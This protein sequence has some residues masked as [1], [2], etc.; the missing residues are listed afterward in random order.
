MNIAFIGQEDRGLS[1][2]R[3]GG[4]ENCFRRLGT[5][6]KQSG[7]EVHYIIYG[8]RNLSGYYIK[9]GDTTFC[10]NYRQLID[11]IASVRADIYNIGPM[12]IRGRLWPLLAKLRRRGA[13]LSTIYWMYP[14]FTGS[15]LVK[16]RSIIFNATIF[17]AIFGGSH[18]IEADLRKRRLRS[19]LLL[20]PIDKCFYQQN[21]KRLKDKKLRVFGY[22]GRI[23][24]DK[25][26]DWFLRQDM[27]LFKMHGRELRIYGYW[28]SGDS[29]SVHF[30]HLLA[31]RPEIKY[32]S[33]PINASC[34][35]AVQVAEWLGLLD[36]I[37]LPY[38]T[39]TGTIDLPLILLESCAAGCRVAVTDVG[40][41]QELL[42]SK[43]MIMTMADSLNDIAER[44]QKQE[45]PRLEEEYRSEIVA[46]KYITCLTNMS[47][48]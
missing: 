8:N 42:G 11:V 45:I 22:I 29:S 4:S 46:Q 1:A 2:K 30:H 43:V 25:G 23:G 21:Q 40:D 47:T 33:F 13:K 7:H 18:R 27:D 19:F 9:N 6:L 39:L 36:G 26:I 17:H 14:V 38:S 35:N 48:P 15:L 10:E 31:Q 12:S 24:E 41:I 32:S 3:I 37:I 16:V 34:C 5:A 20:P 44:M 28:D